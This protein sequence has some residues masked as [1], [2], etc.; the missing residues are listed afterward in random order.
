MRNLT[1]VLNYKCRSTGSLP[2]LLFQVGTPGGRHLGNRA[3][4]LVEINKFTQ[5]KGER[6]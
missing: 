5:V 6:H 2:G 1:S 3:I 4:V